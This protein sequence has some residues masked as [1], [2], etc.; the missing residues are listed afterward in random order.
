MFI[1]LISI[2]VGG[3]LYM[4]GVRSKLHCENGVKSLFIISTICTNCTENI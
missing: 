2:V 3:H 1:T 4:S